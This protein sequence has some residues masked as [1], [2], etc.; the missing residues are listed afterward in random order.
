MAPTDSNRYNIISNL[1]LKKHGPKALHN[2]FDA[3]LKTAV[4]LRIMRISAA[5]RKDPGWLEHVDNDDTQ[6]HWASMIQEKFGATVKDAEYV[7]AELKYYRKLQ[8]Q[9]KNDEIQGGVDMVWIK[10]VAADDEITRQIKEHAA[11]LES[12]TEHENENG[13][14]VQMLIDP[15]LYPL[16]YEV[17]PLLPTPIETYGAALSLN[18]LGSIPGSPIEWAAVVAT[19][20]NSLLSGMPPALKL[21]EV[22][23]LVHCPFSNWLPADIHV[24]ASGKVSIKSYINNLHPARHTAFYSTLSKA[25]EQAIPLLEQVLT[26]V[27]HPRAPRIE[28]D[29]DECIEFTAPHPYELESGLGFD[30][31]SSAMN[32]FEKDAAMEAWEKGIIFKE[33][34]AREFIEPERPFT[35]YRLR[36]QNLQAVVRMK[37]MYLTP[38]SPVIAKHEDHSTRND[39]DKIVATAIYFYDVE[40]ITDAEIGFK[41]PIN[42]G[43][44][45]NEF[46]YSCYTYATFPRIYEDVIDAG[47]CYKY[48]QCSGKI[49]IKSGRWVCFPS[50]Y[51]HYLTSMK[52]A[53]SSKPGHVKMMVFHFVNPV[54]RIPSTS[55]VPPQQREWWEDK[56]LAN[57]CLEIKEHIDMLMTSEQAIEYRKI[58][59]KLNG[60]AYN[61]E[62]QSLYDVFQSCYSFK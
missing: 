62:N 40:N 55:I 60:N 51:L 5:I 4:E 15:S 56:L 1:I 28:Y 59:E 11:T 53:N 41:D 50:S 37:N 33:P 38:E 6:Q 35:P 9:C 34:E 36:N 20:N 18:T 39:N 32:S 54:V 25:M 29:E 14:D 42:A 57:P 44:K 13:R 48:S 16:V 52:L 24:D 30:E 3:A 2:S 31:D 45:D 58:T 61:N 43:C 47:W 19:L 26:D 27:V 8:E 12:E 22:G 23:N 7:L 46:V 21:Y 17:T 49:E 10:D